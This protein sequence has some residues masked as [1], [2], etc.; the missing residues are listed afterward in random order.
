VGKG[1]RFALV[2]PATRVREARVLAK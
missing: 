1:S 2:F